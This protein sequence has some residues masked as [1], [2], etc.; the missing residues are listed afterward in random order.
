MSITIHPTAIVEDGAEIANGVEIGAFSIIGN[1][2]KIGENSKIKSH[3]VISGKTTIGKNNQIFQFSS[4]GEIP[5]DKKYNGEN[6]ALIIG[7]NNVIREN[8]TLHLGTIQDNGVTKI[9]SN[10][11]LMA[12]VH[13]AHDCIVGDNTIF[14][15]SAQLAGHA[16]IGDWAILGGYTGVH[17][18]CKV[19]AHAIT[20]ATSL[21]VQDVPPFLTV[22]GNRAKP[23]GLNVE[24]LKRR[25]FS[26]ENISHLK[27]LYKILYKQNLSLE[28]AKGKIGEILQNESDPKNKYNTQIFLDFLQKSARGIIR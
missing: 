11:L 14:A 3:C 26:A 19:G 20:G 9:G 4:I 15:N 23:F 21:I 24:G 1:Q 10:N 13:I 27:Q 16:E 5:Q 25:K 7:D 6:T 17:Q 22:A 28:E 12:Y 2:V 18:F 8:C